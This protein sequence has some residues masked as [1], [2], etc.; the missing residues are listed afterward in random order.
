[1]ENNAPV[2]PQEKQAEN[3]P[4][5]WIHDVAAG[6]PAEQDGFKIGD[7]VCVFGD[8][9]HKAD[10]EA[11]E[12]VVKTVKQNIDNRVT[13]ELLRKNLVLGTIATVTI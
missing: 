12:L 10:E 9:T 2:I 5:M 8:V 1:M 11:L 4:F 7:A 3:I 13:V 6:S